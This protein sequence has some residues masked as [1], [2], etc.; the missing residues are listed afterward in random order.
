MTTWQFRCVCCQE[1]R[2]A[3]MAR[4]EGTVYLRCIVSR[5]W[6]WYDPSAFVSAGQRAS[7]LRLG[8]GRRGTTAPRGA[9]G[10]RT[11]AAGRAT[12]AP[13]RSTRGAAGRK[14]TKRA[15]KGR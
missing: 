5:Q 15:R 7:A 13:A 2:D 9:A 10:R 3:P 4:P 14:A 1:L 6:A 8:N 12:R 11:R